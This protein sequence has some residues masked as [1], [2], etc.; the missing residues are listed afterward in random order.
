MQ[1][2]RGKRSSQ[3]RLLYRQTMSLY[4]NNT[5]LCYAS[6]VGLFLSYRF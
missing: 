1:E 2:Y 6:I 3:L 5:E 4:G